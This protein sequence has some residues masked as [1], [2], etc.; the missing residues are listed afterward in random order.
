MDWSTETTKSEHGHLK[1]LAEKEI[2]K[3][4]DLQKQLL[5][6]NKVEWRH[7]P[8][9]QAELLLSKSDRQKEAFLYIC[10]CEIDLLAGQYTNDPTESRVVSRMFDWLF[11]QAGIKPP[12]E[13]KPMDTNMNATTTTTA[14]T[15][16]E[17][18]DNSSS[19]WLWT[20]FLALQLEYRRVYESNKEKI[21][22]ASRT[23]PHEAFCSG[24]GRNA[25]QALFFIHWLSPTFRYTEKEFQQRQVYHEILG[26]AQA[27]AK[28]ENY[29]FSRD[30]SSNGLHQDLKEQVHGFFESIV[31]SSL[32][33]SLESSTQRTDLKTFFLAMKE[34][35]AGTYPCEWS[36]ACCQSGSRNMFPYAALTYE[37]KNR[38]FLMGAMPAYR[39]FLET[40][41][42]EEE[43]PREEESQMVVVVTPRAENSPCCSELLRFGFS[44]SSSSSSSGNSNIISPDGS[45]STL[46]LD[47]EDQ[48]LEKDQ[49][50][51]TALVVNTDTSTTTDVHSSSSQCPLLSPN[52]EYEFSRELCGLLFESA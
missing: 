29:L 48:A 24:L 28:L 51:S 5:G 16:N 33:T 34:A 49:E 18:N 22:T 38:L 3:R 42:M 30:E 10:L 8:Q 7:H 39:E 21:Q 32:V 35:D 4:L 11:E 9:L 6:K 27:L 26:D 13:R 44:S 25:D 31:H 52:Y 50:E 41:R 14:T 20:C 1:R 36:D 43:E 15:T 23:F 40:P 17:T 19:S 2:R 46:L 47:E 45:Q 12:S 37:S